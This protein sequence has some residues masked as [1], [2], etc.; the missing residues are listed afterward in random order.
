MAA[1]VSDLNEGKLGDKRT[2]DLVSELND[3]RRTVQAAN[4]QLDSATINRS[5]D[6]LKSARETV[7]KLGSARSTPNADHLEELE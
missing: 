6:L 5:L 1:A 4:G 7:L 2:K 3:M